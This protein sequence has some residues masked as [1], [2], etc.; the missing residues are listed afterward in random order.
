MKLKDSDA[1]ILQHI[2]NYCNQIKATIDLFGDDEKI[3]LQNFIYRNAVSMPVLQI[4]ELVN[5]LSTDFTAEY[6]QIAWREIVGMRN[7]FAHGYQIMNFSE[8][9]NTAIN[10]VPMLN[11]FCKN[12]LR[13]NNFFIPE[14]V[15]FAGGLENV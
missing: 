2:V 9:W 1:Q 3:F 4:G 7:H 11:S 13:E 8:V 5:H 14:Q 12:I 10:D 15:N 6:N